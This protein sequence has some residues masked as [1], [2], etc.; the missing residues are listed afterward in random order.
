[1]I[2]NSRYVDGGGGTVGMGTLPICPA[3]TGGA[4]MGAR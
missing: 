2:E 1:M 3:G 4:K